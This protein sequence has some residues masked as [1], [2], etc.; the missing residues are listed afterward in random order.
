MIYVQF[1]TESRP[2]SLRIKAVTLVLGHW[3][4]NWHTRKN[5]CIA[6]LASIG[7]SLFDKVAQYMK[8]VKRLKLF[9]LTPVFSS[10]YPF[11]FAFT[12]PS[13]YVLFHVMI[14]YKVYLK[15]MRMMTFVC[16]YVD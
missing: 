5:Y 10:F 9:K 7:A 16:V 15:I 11:F 2:P 12:L 14:I 1:E 13:N 6:F 8:F 3:Y 4:M